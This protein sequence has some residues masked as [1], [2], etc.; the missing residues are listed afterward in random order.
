MLSQN[1]IIRNLYKEE[2]RG[3]ICVEVNLLSPAYAHE[4]RI[5]LP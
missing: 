2:M 4:R 1:K 5:A 3:G